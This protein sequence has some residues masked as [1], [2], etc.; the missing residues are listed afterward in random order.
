MYKEMSSPP[1]I[2]PPTHIQSSVYHYLASHTF[3]SLYYSA[4]PIKQYTNMYFNPQTVATVLAYLSSSAIAAPLEDRAVRKLD[5]GDIQQGIAPFCWDKLNVQGYIL[6]FKETAFATTGPH[7]FKLC[8]AKD[9][10]STCFL[11][12][13]FGTSGRDCSKVNATNCAAP[14]A[15]LGKLP[16]RAEM[17]YGSYS[18]WGKSQTIRSLNDGLTR[19]SNP[20][21]HQR[22][23]QCNLRTFDQE[24]RCHSKSSP[25]GP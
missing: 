16:S 7:P 12:D 9:S 4:A 14:E 25:T 8:N 1:E 3:N 18:I 2:S 5:C 24:S 21:L 17:F 19:S 23:V 13:S 6:K 10:W 11:R 22:L 15:A 20:A